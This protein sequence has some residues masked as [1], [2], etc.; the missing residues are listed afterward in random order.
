MCS[1]H[2]NLK[3]R[4]DLFGLLIGVKDIFHIDGFQT[5]AGSRLPANI[6]TGQEAECVAELKKAGVLILGK[7]VTTEFAY[8]APGP[9]KNPHNPVHTP[10]GSSSGS[11]AAV[12]AGM[13]PFTFG[14]QTIGSIIRPAS[15]CGVVGFKPTCQFAHVN[16]PPNFGN[17]APPDFTQNAPPDFGNDVPQREWGNSKKQ[18]H[19]ITQRK[20]KFEP[21]GCMIPE[22]IQDHVLFI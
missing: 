22:W 20:E 10:G 18:K 7:T 17:D 4:P 9:T 13:V 14:T 12:A 19:I 15:F 21:L 8:F 3:D 5:F 6:I 16:V 1:K 11:A 2:P